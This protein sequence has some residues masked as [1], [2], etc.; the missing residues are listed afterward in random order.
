MFYYDHY[1]H[2]FY[3]LNAHRSSL[4]KRNVSPLLLLRKISF[5]GKIFSRYLRVPPSWCCPEWM[6]HCSEKL[7]RCKNQN[8]R[9]FLVGIRFF[10]SHLFSFSCFLKS[11]NNDWQPHQYSDEN[12]GWSYFAAPNSQKNVNYYNRY[13]PQDSPL[14]RS[15]V[16]S[17]SQRLS[18]GA[19]LS[20]VFTHLL[21]P[22]TTHSFIHSL[23][24]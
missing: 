9:R 21:F 5:Q 18:P 17:I 14:K 16:T 22:T 20:F 3:W 4:S 24:H 1:L 8:S 12:T 10:P 23:A 6:R 15:P 2:S 19:L 7:R 11:E 13:L